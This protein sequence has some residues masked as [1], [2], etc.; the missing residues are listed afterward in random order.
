MTNRYKDHTEEMFF[1]S[2]K[3]EKM[4]FLR[5]NFVA[6]NIIIIYWNIEAAVAMDDC[7]HPGDWKCGD[8]CM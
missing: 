3:L 4:M 7:K 2:R 1:S 5:F 6:V 8:I